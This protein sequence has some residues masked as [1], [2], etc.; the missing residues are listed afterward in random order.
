[1]ALTASRTDLKYADSGD[2]YEALQ[3]G[4]SGDTSWVFDNKTFIMDI[5]GSTDDASPLLSLTTVNSRIVVD[6]GALRILHLY[7]AK[8]VY[9][10]ALVPGCYVYDLVMVD[11]ITTVR[12]PLMYGNLEIIHGATQE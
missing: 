2:L 10:A 4:T 7:V 8:A 12:T 11:S 6:S 1:M 9:E 3:F 5:K